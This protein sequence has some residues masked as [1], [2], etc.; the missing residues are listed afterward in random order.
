MVDDRYAIDCESNVEFNSIGTEFYCHLER[1]LSIFRGDTSS[2]S[3][4]EYRWHTFSVMTAGK[5]NV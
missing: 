2:S 1:C 5:G 4:G 3:M